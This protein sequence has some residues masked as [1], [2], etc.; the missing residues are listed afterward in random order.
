[1]LLY[2]ISIYRHCQCTNQILLTNCGA[3]SQFG[4]VR[5]VA[6]LRNTQFT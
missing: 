2:G 5:A 4:S 3:P 1:L 6:G